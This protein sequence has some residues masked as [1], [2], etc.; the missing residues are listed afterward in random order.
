MVLTW[1]RHPGTSLLDYAKEEVKKAQQFW[2]S[3]EGEQRKKVLKENPQSLSFVAGSEGQTESEETEEEETGEDDE[4]EGSLPFREKR[5]Q[6]WMDKLQEELGVK[7][8]EE[9]APEEEESASTEPDDASSSSHEVGVEPIS[10]SEEEAHEED[11]KEREKEV[12]G[13]KKKMNK[14]L[15]RKLG[16]HVNEVAFQE[17]KKDE[18]PVKGVFLQRTVRRTR[19]RWS[20]LEVFTWTCAISLVAAA[21]HWQ[22][23]EPETLPRW[24]LMKEKDYEEALAYIDR[25]DPDLLVL[26]WPCGPWSPL[27]TLGQKTPFQRAKLVQKREEN[28]MLLRFVRDASLAQR[29]RGGA[30]LGENPKPS[31]A[32]KEPLIEEAFSGTSMA[33][34]D[35]CMFGLRVPDGPHL[36]KRTRLQGTEE[37]T[38]RCEKLCDKSHDHTPVVGGIKTHGTWMPLSEYAGGYTTRFAKEVALGAEQFLK[39]KRKHR[40][41]MVEGGEVPEE[42]MM[43]EEEQEEQ[44]EHHEEIEEEEM[45]RGEKGWKVVKIHQRLGHPSKATLVKMLTLAGAPKEMVEL[46]GRYDCPT[47]AQVSAPS[48]YPKINPVTRTSVFAKEVHLDLKY[49]H[50]AANKLHVALSLVDGGTSFHA[51][52]LLRNRKADYVARKFLRRWCSMYGTPATVY[53]DQGGEFDEAF[54]GWLEMHGIYS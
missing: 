12:Q 53:V 36:R 10:S 42:P 5:M 29:K 27:Q 6:A 38:H 1:T 47:C 8:I 20:V 22:F 24:D 49:M 25:V 45:K 54:V 23:H 3:K 51:A 7:I 37:I 30:I 28:R 18:E 48:R 52:C 15:K 41:V 32:W 4:E 34:S 43:E 44:E 14:H 13:P 46:A 35:M 16:H 39:K 19:S 2:N 21:R 17:G 26:A 50:D 11:A 31:L 9:V 40:E 33:I